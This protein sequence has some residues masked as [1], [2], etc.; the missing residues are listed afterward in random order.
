[1]PD[2]TVL[3]P[4][5]WP[6]GDSRFSEPVRIFIESSLAVLRNA[7]DGRKRMLTNIYRMGR[8]SIEAGQTGTRFYVIPAD[9]RHA[10]EAHNLVNILRSGGVEIFRAEESMQVEGQRIAA[11]SFV[12]PTAQAFRPFVVDLLEK[13]KFPDTRLDPSGETRS[14]YDITGW[15]LPMQMG[16]EV[17]A[18]TSDLD[19]TRRELTGDVSMPPGEIE[20]RSARYGYA[21]PYEMNLAVKVANRLMAEGETVYWANEAFGPRDALGE[22]TFVI[23]ASDTMNERAGIIA[24]E[25]GVDLIRL[26]SAP[27]VELTPLSLPTVG[28]YKS[29]AASKDEGWTRFIME[30]YGF[31]MT[32]LMDSDLRSGDLSDFDAIILPDPD[33]RVWYRN[34]AAKLLNGHPAGTMPEE[35]TGGMGL[36]GALNIDRFVRGGGTLVTFGAASNFAIHHFNLPI[37]NIVSGAPR[38]TFSIPG[39]LIRAK[40]NRVSPLAYG[41][42]EEFAVNFVNGGAY[43]PIGQKDCVG[44]YL[45]Q[46]DCIEIR[47]GG[48][49]LNGWPEPVGHVAPVV[50][51]DEDLLMSGWSKGE[52]YIA[53]RTAV[54]EVAHGEGKVVLFGFRPQ[55]RAQPRGTYKLVFNSLLEAASN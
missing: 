8:D 18:T 13:Q 42:P 7:A 41:M 55:F 4:D 34:S 49:P 45:N 1:M 21:L 5:P 40:L 24:S 52:D 16:V 23:E 28:L 53:S 35:F 39:S 36:E 43:M 27:S 51:A 32:N 37:R 46:G 19:V 14:P 44:D 31:A 26:S 48:R 30:E 11:G 6:G 3:Y 38:S 12:I 25:Y 29:Y 10:D 47:R 15:T 33:A 20:G 17:I 22:G 9:Q 54:A 50:Y 2:A